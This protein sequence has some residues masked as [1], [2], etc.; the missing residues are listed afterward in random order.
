MRHD[1]IGGDILPK[2]EALKE[3]QADAIKVRTGATEAVRLA[4]PADMTAGVD[5]LRDGSKPPAL[6]EPKLQKVL[7]DAERHQA[8]VTAALR[9]EQQAF[10]EDINSRRDEILTALATAEDEAST[11]LA[12]LLTQVEEAMTERAE[13]KAHVFWLA[14]T[15]RSLGNVKV[16]GVEL[17]DGLRE[18]VLGPVSASDKQVASEDHAAKVDAWNTMVRRAC[19]TLDRTLGETVDARHKAAEWAI[20]AEIDR[21]RA[22]GEPIPEPTNVKWRQ[23]LGVG[24]KPKGQGTSWAQTPKEVPTVLVPDTAY[25]EARHKDAV[26]A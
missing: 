25:Q 19:L 2:V 6:T 5:A 1:L 16:F 3:Q 13:I 17:V 18:K 8:V 14:D 7:D 20:E 21:M 23:K 10:Q 9:A 4:K 22:A 24:V 11:T 26:P 15:T 12:D